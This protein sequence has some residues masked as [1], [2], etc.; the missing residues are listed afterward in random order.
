MLKTKSFINFNIHLLEQNQDKIKWS[1][2]SSNPN[3]IHLLEQN[4]DKISWV[5]LSENPNAIHILEQNLDNICWGPLSENPNAIQ[6]LEQ[7]QDKICLCRLLKN[8]SIFEYDYLNI[9]KN[10]CKLKQELVEV[11]LNPIN[12]D[13]FK[14]W[15]Y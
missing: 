15:G 3:A 1:I 14:E 9:K 11:V 10:M 8:P 2:L 7:N 13:K 5:W 12:Y 4:P 6:L